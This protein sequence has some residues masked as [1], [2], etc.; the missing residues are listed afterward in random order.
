MDESASEPREKVSKMET[1]DRS[2]DVTEN[3]ENFEKLSGKLDYSLWVGR[4]KLKRKINEQY[5]NCTWIDVENQITA[6][7]LAT[8]QKL[9]APMCFEM[10]F[11]REKNTCKIECFLSNEKLGHD[12]FRHL[13]QSVQHF[14]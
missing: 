3:A 14:Q 5:K 6:Q 1:D 11:S 13:S 12:F 8:E 4:R 2:E 10:S 7:L 9:K